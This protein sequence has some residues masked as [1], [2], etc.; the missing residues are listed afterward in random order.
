MAPLLGG[1]S[2][3]PFPSVLADGTWTNIQTHVLLSL[4]FVHII[5]L[6]L[7]TDDIK[8]GGAFVIDSCGTMWL[9]LLMAQARI[10]AG[11][12]SLL[13]GR[14]WRSPHMTLSRPSWWS[15]SG[16]SAVTLLKYPLMSRLWRP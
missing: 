2:I 3:N 6:V 13:R 16:R 7:V 15:S 14:T 1:C 9:H 8:R 11:L 10:Q 5:S 12:A 4:M